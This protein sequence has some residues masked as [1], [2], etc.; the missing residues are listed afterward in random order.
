MQIVNNY[1]AAAGESSLGSI[2][3][4]NAGKSYAQSYAHSFR[5]GNGSYAHNC[6]QLKFFTKFFSVLPTV[7]DVFHRL[8]IFCH[9]IVTIVIIVIFLHSCHRDGAYS[10][11]N[12]ASSVLA[13][14]T[15]SVF[16]VCINKVYIL[17]HTY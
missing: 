10:M 4:S 12:C 15:T 14:I 8:F 7:F 9:Q 11:L 16:T 5:W 1:S 13:M 17:S 2:V 6:A 3:S